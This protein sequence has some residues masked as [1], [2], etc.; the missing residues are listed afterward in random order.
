ML[1]FGGVSM[2]CNMNGYYGFDYHDDKGNLAQP[3]VGY[4]YY[5]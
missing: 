3:M 4:V 5:F 2:N 1:I